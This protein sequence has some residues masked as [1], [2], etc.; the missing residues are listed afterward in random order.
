MTLEPRWEAVDDARRKSISFLYARGLSVDTAQALS[1]VVCELL[2]NGFKYGAF[3]S[4]KDR[5]KLEITV[6][7][8]SATI[9]VLNP[10]GDAAG[11]HLRRLDRTVQWIR[12]F[13]DPFEAYIEKLKEVAKKP[14]D[15]QESGL[16][17]VRIAYEG[18]A[19]LDFF[20]PEAG[21]LNVSAVA[22]LGQ[23]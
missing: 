23:E 11:E 22:H 9:E 3:A 20:V 4:E 10:F 7:D 13:Q 2:E 16:G 18:R 15:D 6:T 5:L 21:V 17:L 1:M 19:I 8:T 12:G 14:L